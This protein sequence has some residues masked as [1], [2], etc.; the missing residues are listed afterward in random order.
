MPLTAAISRTCASP[1]LLSTIVQLTSSPSGLSGQRSAFCLYCASV[2]PQYAGAVPTSSG[3][4]PPFDLKRIAAMPACTSSALSVS[5]NMMPLTP[6]FSS[7]LMFCPRRRHVGRDLR[8][9]HHQRVREARERRLGQ[10]AGVGG[11]LDE[12]GDAADRA[13][14]AAFHAAVEEEVGVAV[15]QRVLR[16]VGRRLHDGVSRRRSAAAPLR[17]ARPVDAEQRLLLLE[18]IDH[19][20]QPLARLRLS[21]D[22]CKPN[23]ESSE[24]QP[25]TVSASV[26]SDL[27]LRP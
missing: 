13:I 9:L 25:A 1:S 19:R 11:R 8:R 5:T 26:T 12:V 22:A 7:R 18:Q 24:W 2:M 20:V 14:D 21:G 27:K 15:R 6:R 17:I 4:V 3:R 10:R 23:G 16:P